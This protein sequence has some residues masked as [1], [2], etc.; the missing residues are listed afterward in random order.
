MTLRIVTDSTC[1]LPRALAAAHGITVLPMYINRGNESYLDDAGF[2]RTQFYTQL[3]SYNPMP[4]TAAAGPEHFRRAYEALAAEGATEILSLHVASSLSAVVNAANIAAKETRGVRVTVLDSRQVSLGL[5]FLALAAAEAAASGRTLAEIVDR[6]QGQITRTYVFAAL[7]TLEFLRRSGRV[8]K[9]VASLSS[10]LQ[11]KPI[12]KVYDGAVMSERART[13]SQAVQRLREL[14]SEC[15]PL[16]RAAVLYTGL[17]E[18]AEELL[19]QVQPLLP[20]GEVLRVEATPVIGTHIGPGAMG[21]ACVMAP[22]S[23]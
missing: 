11:I 14:L 21:L 15:A 7:D 16:E 9:L 12:L 6:L 2:S 5:G 8:N 19:A 13:H 23:T 3:A 18:R 1:D 22:T 17:P 10:L 20:A 4:T